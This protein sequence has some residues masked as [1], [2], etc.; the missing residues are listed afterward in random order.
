[1][2][3]DKFGFLFGK[4]TFVFIKPKTPHKTYYRA[5]KNVGLFILGQPR[6]SP[7][8]SRVIQ[9]I[10]TEN[11]PGISWGLAQPSQA[12]PSQAQPGPARPS[13]ARPRPAWKPP[14]N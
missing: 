10:H 9:K 14:A 1:L 2:A 13:P 12:Q 7:E 5:I 4:I 8:N 3:R 6:P 11:H